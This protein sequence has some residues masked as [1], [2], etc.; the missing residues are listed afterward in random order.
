MR[1]RRAP[2]VAATLVLSL[3]AAPPAQAVTVEKLDLGQMVE[4]AGSIA[5]VTVLDARPSNVPAGGAELPVTL[6]SVRVEEALAGAL[7]LAE[8]GATSVLRFLRN[9]G[10]V[11]RNGLLHRSNLPELP[12]LQVGGRYL[13]LTTTPSLIGLSAPVGLEQGVFRITG[14]PGAETALNG[15]GNG[16]LFT[17]IESIAPPG[18]VS[19]PIRSDILATIIHDLAAG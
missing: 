6:Y 19:G 14:K 18:W 7:P 4:Q 13:I 3:L 11:E 10:T 8:D 2:A 12:R 16:G 9:P 1:A 15:L 5:V 17:G